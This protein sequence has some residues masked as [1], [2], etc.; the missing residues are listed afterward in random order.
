MSFQTSLRNAMSILP[1]CVR[2]VLPPLEGFA[3]SPSP[4][5]QFTLAAAP[6]LSH[7]A[8][9]Q[10]VY[11]VVSSH[12]LLVTPVIPTLQLSPADLV[13]PMRL[14]L[15]HPHPCLLNHSMC[16]CGHPMDALVTHLLRCSHGGERTAAH[17]VVCDAM[18]Y[19]IRDAGRA[20][21][22]ERTGF[23]P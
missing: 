21:V 18:Y 3:C 4:S 17:N 12:W 19:I 7:Q 16:T 1:P 23:L 20:F 6:S 5:L 8:R 11:G 15:G 13:T 22:R 14:R 9:L 2:V 10:S